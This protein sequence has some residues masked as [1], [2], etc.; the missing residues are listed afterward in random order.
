VHQKTLALLRFHWN[1]CPQE[2][3][4]FLEDLLL[5]AAQEHRQILANQRILV[6]QLV[7]LVLLV[8][9]NPDYLQVRVSR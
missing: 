4:E 3:L 9:A 1:Q 6:A 2:V 7:Q 8:Q 5:L